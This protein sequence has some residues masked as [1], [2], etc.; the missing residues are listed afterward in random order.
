M[1]EKHET[2]LF[3]EVV[4]ILIGTVVLVASA[5]G[6]FILAEKATTSLRALCLNDWLCI[7]GAG[8]V[9][10]LCYMVI[11]AIF[12]F[13]LE[14]PI[15]TLLTRS[16]GSF[17]VIIKRMKHVFIEENGCEELGLSGLI[18]DAEKVLNEKKNIL[19]IDKIV[20]AG[21]YDQLQERFLEKA[22]LDDNKMMELYIVGTM[23]GT[24][25]T[26]GTN[27]AQYIHEKIKQSG[28]T[29]FSK[30][31]FCSPGHRIIQNRKTNQHNHRRSLYPLS[32][33]IVAGEILIN[34]HDAYKEINI[35]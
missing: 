29:P 28:H 6:S 22:E 23:L 14:V 31:Y 4:K 15:A 7:G 19:N 35:E 18:K 5:A 8:F 20:I 26:D 13:L 27:L 25:S 9:L 30:A 17:N 2:T 33:R 16:V 21:N 1:P 3:I 10:A 11:T 32:A 34:I 12:L 24:Y